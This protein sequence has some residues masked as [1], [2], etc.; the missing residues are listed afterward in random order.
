VDALGR[1]TDAI[2]E[3]VADQWRNSLEIGAQLAEMVDKRLWRE[4]LDLVEYAEKSRQKIGDEAMTARHLTAH[5]VPITRVRVRQLLGAARLVDALNQGE[6]TVSP[7]SERT[8]R[9]L[10]DLDVPIPEK[11][12]LWQEA[13]EVAR[14]VQPAAAEVRAVVRSHYPPAPR[15]RRPV[16][17]ELARVIRAYGALQVVAAMKQVLGESAESVT[18]IG[19]RK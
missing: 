12:A 10:V 5:G 7:S 3:L 18:T 1:T 13:V 6:T 17:D 14:F 4:N 8:I 19:R 16:K 2:R 9:P 11:V 15:A